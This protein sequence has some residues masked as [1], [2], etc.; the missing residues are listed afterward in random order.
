MEAKLF[1]EA[2]YCCKTTFASIFSNTIHYTWVHLDIIK[3]RTK[4]YVRYLAKSYLN[5]TTGFALCDQSAKT[6]PFDAITL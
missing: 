2:I 6:S 5:A 1:L 4:T 3:D